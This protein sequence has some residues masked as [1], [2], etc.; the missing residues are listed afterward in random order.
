MRAN[1]RDQRD[2]TLLMIIIIITAITSFT[3]TA[4]IELLPPTCYLYY[5][6]S[7]YHYS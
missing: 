4:S 7:Y 2:C 5:D 3:F 1:Q 6:D